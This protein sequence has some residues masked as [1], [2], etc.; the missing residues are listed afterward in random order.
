MT[1]KVTFDRWNSLQVNFKEEKSWNLF[2]VILSFLPASLSGV[3]VETEK[4]KTVVLALFLHIS[5]S[6]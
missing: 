4:T 1:Y 6:R 3:W 5:L 2:Y